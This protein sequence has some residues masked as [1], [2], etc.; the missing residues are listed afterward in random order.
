MFYAKT[1]I[2]IHFLGLYNI[3]KQFGRMFVWNER[4]DGYKRSESYSNVNIVKQ[5]KTRHTQKYNKNRK[6]S[7]TFVEYLGRPTIIITYFLF[8]LEWRFQEERQRR[9]RG[10]R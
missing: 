4:G 8:F 3:N 1:H 7:R 2:H 9:F 5:K 6:Q 10:K